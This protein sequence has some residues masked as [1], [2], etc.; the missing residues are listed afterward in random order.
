MSKYFLINGGLNALIGSFDSKSALQAAAKADD[1]AVVVTN[2]NDIYEAL[3][4]PEMRRIRAD[5]A[6]KVE[7]AEDPETRG[8]ALFQNDER[9]NTKAKK[10]VQA[11]RLYDDLRAAAGNPV[12]VSLSKQNA[13]TPPEGAP[14]KAPR[15]PRRN[16]KKHIRELFPNVGDTA[17]HE[18]VA[19]EGEDAY[20]DVSITTAMSDLRSEKYCGEGDPIRIKRVKAEDGS[21][22]YVREA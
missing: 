13:E 11:Q 22:S 15:A 10:M 6:A 3:S 9:F 18:Q 1:D 2:P 14:K 20:T 17:T 8:T 19:G 4:E 5:V 16:I 21:V 7:G 12:V